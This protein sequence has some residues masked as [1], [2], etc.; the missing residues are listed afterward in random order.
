MSKFMEKQRYMSK[1]FMD[2]DV[3]FTD[4][5][6]SK[7]VGN[8]LYQ[9]GGSRNFSILKVK[10]VTHANGKVDIKTPRAML[11][12]NSKWRCSIDK[13]KLRVFKK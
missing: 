1:I 3:W 12:A 10:H 9:D 8:I 4:E 2:N 7:Y 11:V 6:G 5:K 13:T